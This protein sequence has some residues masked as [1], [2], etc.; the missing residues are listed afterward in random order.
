ML[1]I[2]CFMDLFLKRYLE[3]DDTKKRESWE[4]W[5]FIWKS[6]W[7]KILYQTIDFL[8]KNLFFIWGL[9]FSTYEKSIQGWFWS[10]L[11]NNIQS[12]E[13]VNPNTF[14]WLI[15]K[16]KRFFPISSVLLIIIMKNRY[17][18]IWGYVRLFSILS[19]GNFFT[20]NKR[21]NWK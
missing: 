5:D 17:T 1:L 15:L 19:P 21:V 14:N 3:F 10:L 18:V 2:F 7:T 4:K 6:S 13:R 16:Q 20:V 8:P 11:E 9:Y 12:N